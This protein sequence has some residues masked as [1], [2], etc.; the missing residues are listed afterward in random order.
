MRS[1][2][3][4]FGTGIV[5]VGDPARLDAL[6]RSAGAAHEL[7]GRGASSARTGAAAAA[8]GPSPPR[9]KT[10]PCSGPTTSSASHASRC[11]G[12]ATDSSATA[13]DGAEPLGLAGELV[14]DDPRRLGRHQ[15]HAGLPGGSPR[16][17]PA[18]HG[19][20]LEPLGEA[21]ARPCRAGRARRDPRRRGR[22]PPTLRTESCSARPI[23]RFARLPWPRQL[24]AA[25]IPTAVGQRPETTTTGPAGC[26][27]ASRPCIANSGGRPPRPRR[28]RSGGLRRAA[29]HHRVDRHLLHGRVARR[30]AAPRRRRP[31]GRGCAARASRTTRSGVGGT[32]G[33]P[34]VT[35]RSCSA[36]I[37]S[38]S[39][40]M[41]ARARAAAPRR[42]R[43]RGQPRGDL[44]IARAR[45][46]AR[47]HAP[48][49]RRARASRRPRRERRAAA[50]AAAPRRGR[51][52]CPPSSSSDRR[53][54]LGVERART[55]PSSSSSS[56]HRSRP[57]A[58]A[59]AAVSLGVGL[60]QDPHARPPPRGVE[61]RAGPDRRPG[62]RA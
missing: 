17:W 47:P 12:C 34:S 59:C 49:G 24:P 32:T 61:R 55:A 22:P 57:S 6:R 11:F 40:P 15:R 9:A 4:N 26:V 28:G 30:T 48:A 43:A 25:F 44:G 20:P 29:G 42:G 46:A 37:G 1:G 53:H 38:S 3:A 33:R 39:S 58:R 5:G 54:G 51:A 23:V 27:V 14:D 31:A 10:R 45:R 50:R 52:R 62:S 8:R 7:A 36:S 56:G 2:A 16:S 18:G 13:S 35:P 41:R 60:R 21:R 19:D